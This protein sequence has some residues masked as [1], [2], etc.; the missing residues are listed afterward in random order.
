[1]QILCSL[2]KNKKKMLN[3]KVNLLKFGDCK[4]NVRDVTATSAFYQAEENFIE[5]L[6][7]IKKYL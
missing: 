6:G 4:K 7:F 5:E 3:K 1:M 2:K